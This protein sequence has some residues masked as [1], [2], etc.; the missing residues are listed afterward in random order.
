MKEQAVTS[1]ATLRSITR[2]PNDGGPGR[3]VVR[4]FAPIASPGE[5][6]LHFGLDGEDEDRYSCLE[7]YGIRAGG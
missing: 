5:N 3:A 1:D 7:I 4:V 2:C 6:R